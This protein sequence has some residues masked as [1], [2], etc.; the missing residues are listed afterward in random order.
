VQ[1]PDDTEG[2]VAKR[3]EVYEAQ[4]APLIGFY[5]GK[6]MLRRID[7]DAALETVTAR[8]EAALASKG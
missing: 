8:V 2:T 7:A 3:I 5:E 4:T 6:G 1:R